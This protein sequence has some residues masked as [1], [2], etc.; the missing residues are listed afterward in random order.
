MYVP[1]VRESVLSVFQSLA[2]FIA[3]ISGCIWSSC[4]WCD[5]ILYGWI[6]LPCVYASHFLRP[7]V[8]PVLILQCSLC[9]SLPNMALQT[10]LCSAFDSL[11][12]TP[13]CGI[14]KLYATSVFS[15]SM[16]DPILWVPMAEA[17]PQGICLSE[18]L[19][20]C[21]GEGRKTGE[22]HPQTERLS[23]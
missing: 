20:T 16:S 10:P 17:S 7:L 13:R 2:H 23:P 6:I 3:K 22:N 11:G 8:A 21:P 12:N 18:Q 14:A 9:E 5:F 15:F 1:C 19:P 4:K